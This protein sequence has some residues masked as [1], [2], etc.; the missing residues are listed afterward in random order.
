MHNFLWTLC[1]KIQHV[2][3]LAII[4]YSLLQ[5]NKDRCCSIFIRNVVQL[6]QKEEESGVLFVVKE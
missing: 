3:A 5:I 6:T 1:I 2:S 4:A